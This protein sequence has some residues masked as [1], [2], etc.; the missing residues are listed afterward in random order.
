MIT[1]FDFYDENE[2]LAQYG[3]ADTD[4]VGDG[5]GDE[6]RCSEC[7]AFGDYQCSEHG[8]ATIQA[9]REYHEHYAVREALETLLT[10]P[11]AWHGEAWV[12]LQR[13]AGEVLRD[14]RERWG[15]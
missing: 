8:E 6:E 7:D 3:E 5:S 9:Q 13:R 14:M 1:G 10:M 4:D 15:E 2:D 11:E 12:E